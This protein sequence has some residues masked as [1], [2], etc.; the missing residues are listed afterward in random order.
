MTWRASGR[1][2]KVSRRSWVEARAPPRH[3]G[4]TEVRSGSGGVP[5]GRRSARSSARSEELVALLG[6][7][8]ASAANGLCFRPADSAAWGELS[9]FPFFAI[10]GRGYPPCSWWAH[11]IERLPSAPSSLRSRAAPPRG[12]TS[13]TFARARKHRALRLFARA[14]KHRALRPFARARK[15]R[16]LRPFARARSVGSR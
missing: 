6:S 5:A 4:V 1:P 16:A 11:V 8:A 12:S 3:V 2:P 14:R 7:F 10:L 15:H 13:C 9:D